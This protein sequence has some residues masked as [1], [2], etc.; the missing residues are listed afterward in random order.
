MNTFF[1]GCLILAAGVAVA[2]DQGAHGFSYHSTSSHTISV[3]GDGNVTAVDAEAAARTE[4]RQVDTFTSIEISAPVEMKYQASGLPSLMITAPADAL[5]FIV[6]EVRDGRLVIRVKDNTSLSLHDTIR[7]DATGPS[8][9]AVVVSSSAQFKGL[10]I[11]GEKFHAEVSGSGAIDASGN[12]REVEITVSC[13]GR[14]DTAAIHAKKVS[15]TISGAASVRAF[16]SR[17]VGGNVSGA[18]RVTIDGDPSE[19]EVDTSG[20]GRITFTSDN[21]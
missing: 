4:E 8:P 6:T 5:A 15:V 14:V 1:T 7:V 18:G 11:T 3:H 17:E 13:S 19:R 12:V 9:D 2:Q 21:N 20:A 16:A 10:G